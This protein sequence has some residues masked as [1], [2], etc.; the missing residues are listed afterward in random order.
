MRIERRFLPRLL[1]MRA[2]V[3]FMMGSSLTSSAESLRLKSGTARPRRGEVTSGIL[4]SFHVIIVQEAQTHFSECSTPTCAQIS[5]E[6]VGCMMS[7]VIPD[8]SKR[9][10]FGLCY[11][12]VTSKFRRPPTARGGSA[13]QQHATTRRTMPF[14]RAKKKS[15]RRATRTSSQVISIPR[16]SA[17]EA[18]RR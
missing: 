15:H 13:P 18:R 10:A 1:Q 4:G 2:V 3:L 11:L 7:K 17:N 6:P 16:P 14:G 9:D 8:T 5:F 12:V